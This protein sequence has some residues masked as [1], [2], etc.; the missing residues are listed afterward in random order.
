MAKEFSIDAT[1]MEPPEPLMLTLD[2]VEDLGPGDYIRFRHRREPVPL[3]D[4]LIQSGFSFL[5]C[6]GHDVKFEIFI[7]RKNDAKAQSLIKDKIEL[8]KLAVIDSSLSS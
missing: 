4:S 8:A 2:M 7:W 1:E 6:T 5:T 3:Y